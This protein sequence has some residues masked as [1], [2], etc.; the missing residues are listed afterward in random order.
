MLYLPYNAHRQYQTI[1]GA[2][3]TKQGKQTAIWLMV[4]IAVSLLVAAVI[5]Q[6]A[7]NRPPDS[8]I[9]HPSTEKLTEQTENTAVSLKALI[10]NP[11]YFTPVFQSWYGKPAPDLTLTDIT[12]KQHKLSDYRGKDVIIVFWAT[13]CMPCVTEIPHLTALRNVI[14]ED[15]LAILAISNENLALVENFVARK[16]INYTVISNRSRLPEP[17]SLVRAIPCSF[18]L[19]AEGKLKLATEGTLSLGV[20]KAILTAK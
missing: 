9:H 13:W 8:K 12:G 11:K 6:T 19:D 5:W 4:L 2:R 16:K 14:S 18:F 3:M 17:F 1:K 20:M 15:K 10:E 7:K